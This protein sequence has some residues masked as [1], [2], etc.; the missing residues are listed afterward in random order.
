MQNIVFESREEADSSKC[1]IKLEKKNNSTYC[2]KKIKDLCLDRINFNE[3]FTSCRD[4]LKV[5]LLKE[6]SNNIMTTTKKCLCWDLIKYKEN[7][8]FAEH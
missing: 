6:K 5:K 3:M 8:I 2:K 7:T 1:Q 4:K